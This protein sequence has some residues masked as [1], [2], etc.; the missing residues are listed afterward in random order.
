MRPGPPPPDT[1]PCARLPRAP[2]RPAEAHPD[3]RD[4]PHPPPPPSPPPARFMCQGG[5][6]T[7]G[8][9]TGG[10]SIYGATFDD[11]NFKAKHSKKGLLSMANA[12]PATN[13]SQFFVTVAATPHLDG[14][15]CVFGE[16]AEA[17]GASSRDPPR[18]PVVPVSPARCVERRRDAALCTCVRAAAAGVR[19]CGEDRGGGEQ[20][21]GAG[22]GGGDHRLR[23]AGP[24]SGGSRGAAAGESANLAG[25]SSGQRTTTWRLHGV[26]V[27]DGGCRLRAAPRQ[28]G[29]LW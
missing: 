1:P 6:F 7:D 25:V 24:L 4:Q 11:E 13:G 2:A 19:R 20:L 18:V 3:S 16:V 23:G 14:R 5:D 12:G 9:G 22:Q 15:H 28:R 29:W 21:G 17:R 27:V 26:L 8:N 10:E